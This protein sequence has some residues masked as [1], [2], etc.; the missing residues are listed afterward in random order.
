MLKFLNLFKS[1]DAPVQIES[2]RARFERVTSELNEVLAELNDM[3]VVTI[4]AA[5]Q[6]LSIAAPEQ[7]MDE[8]LALPSPSAAQEAAKE[9]GTP[10]KDADAPDKAS[11]ISPDNATESAASKS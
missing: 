8:A 10:A 4:D 1:G 6:T 11:D 2:H 5:A 7:F 3:P 9:T